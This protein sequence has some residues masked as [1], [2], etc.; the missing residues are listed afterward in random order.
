[1]AKRERLMRCEA[2]RRCK[3]VCAHKKK[4]K[5]MYGWVDCL[6][7]CRRSD[8]VPGAVCKPVKGGRG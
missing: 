6:S 2:W 8:G 5:K 4:H 1:M 3:G 7:A